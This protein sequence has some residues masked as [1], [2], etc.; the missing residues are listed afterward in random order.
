MGN[1]EVGHMSIGSGRI[2]LQDLPRIDRAIADRS[3]AQN[4]NLKK[5]I[6]D[7][8]ISEKAAIF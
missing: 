3:L 4:K 5:F 1:S 2:V 6:A 7:L 8:K